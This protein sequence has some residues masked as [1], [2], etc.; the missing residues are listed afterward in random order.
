MKCDATHGVVS[1]YAAS[2]S[3]V[4][5][6]AEWCNLVSAKCRGTAEPID[7]VLMQQKMFR[8]WKQYLMQMYR[9]HPRSTTGGKYRVL[10]H[11]WANF[12]WG[13][14]TNGNAVYHP[15]EMWLYRCTGPSMDEWHKEEPVKVVFAKN[16]NRDGTLPARQLLI[17]PWLISKGRPLIPLSHDQFE[18]YDGP[19][20]MEK[21][22]QKDLRTLSKYLNQWMDQAD[23]DRLYPEPESGSDEEGSGEDDFS[24]DES[25]SD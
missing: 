20:P 6:T 25:A 4:A 23:I 3:H 16:V 11:H 19:I 9:K 7:S 14:D 10:D 17:L 12:G 15:H 2:L 21:A 13:K 24:S 5:S 8:Q 22:K 1:R 18:S